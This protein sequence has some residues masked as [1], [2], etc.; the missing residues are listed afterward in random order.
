MALVGPAGYG[1]THLF[2]RLNYQQGER[3]QFAFLAAPSGSDGNDKNEQLESVL[4][5]RLVDSLL[6]SVN[7]IA[8]FRLVL[9]RLLAPSFLAYFDQLSVGL[10]ARCTNIRNGLQQE[11]F[12]V[13]E[14]LGQVESLASYHQLADAVRPM[15]PTCSGA[16]IRALV[17]SASSSADDA[18]LWLRGEADQVLPERLELFRLPSYSPLLSEII[19]AI[20]EILKAIKVTFV[21]CFD[22]LEELF[23]NDLAGFTALTSLIMVWLQTIPNLIIGIGCLKE[24]WNRVTG[25]EGFQSFIQRVKVFE[26]PDMSG[27]EAADLV[28]RRMRSWTDFDPKKAPGW[29]FDLESVKAYADRE[30]PSPRYFLQKECAIRFNEW[31]TNKRVG[32]IRFDKGPVVVPLEESFRQ[33]WTR[34]LQ[35]KQAEHRPASELHDTDLWAG[36]NEAL[37]IAKLGGYR[38]DLLRIDAIQPHPIKRTPTAP[39]HS[40]KVNFTSAGQSGSVIVSVSKKDSGNVFGSWVTALYD[41]MDPTVTGAVAVWPRSEL[42]VGKTSD[43]YKKYDVKVKAGHIRPFPLDEEENTLYQLET[44]RHFISSADNDLLLNGKVITKDECRDLIV[45]AGLLANLKLFEFLFENWQALSGGTPAAPPPV[46][47][48][49]PEPKLEMPRPTPPG[50]IYSPSAPAPSE[51]AKAAGGASV[52][53]PLSTVVS[54]EPSWAETILK[55]AV[56]Y[57]QKRGQTVDPIGVESGPTFLRLKVAL[58]GDA[59]FS[60]VRRQSENLKVHLSLEHEPLIK[61]QAGFISID[62][63]RPDRVFV[64]LAALL[65]KCPPNLAG[66]PAIPAGVGVSGTTEWLNLS[67]PESCHLLVAG[68]TGSGKSEFLKAM[69]AAL[70]TRLEPTEVRFRLIDPKRV[71]FNIDPRCPYLGGPVVYDGGEALPV[72]EEC[73]EEMERRYQLL[74]QRHKDH[75]RHL[76]G[77]DVVPRWVVVFDEFAD[78]MTDRGTKKLLG[79]LLQRLGAKARA[80]GIHLVLGTQRPESSVVTPLLRSNLPGRIGL[81]VASE[82]ESKLFLDEPDAAYLFGKGDLVWKRGGGLIRLQSPY[83]TEAEFNQCLRVAEF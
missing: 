82:R 36:V 34:T 17:L 37:T 66:E 71:T 11:P 55:K 38:R 79:P 21:I 10:Q 33:E 69:L 4:R 70:A 1:K 8:P 68:T 46:P 39:R 15:F 16:I 62:V 64:A 44:L 57:L 6:Y 50:Q 75:V 14:I 61:S 74:Q 35:A 26:L 3:V 60:K 54:A 2:G 73:V 41:A 72:L 53:P 80:A 20:A 31:L 77:S 49:P 40:A 63:Q 56:L 7:S 47:T 18:R 48:M 27:A 45:G 22:Q 67:E 76:T 43:G 5:W 78:L 51:H 12:K 29:P 65:E 81:R 83:V 19:L 52:K 32:W 42:A 25:A 23:K 13:L 59:D 9:A 58:R 30:G 28:G 24:T